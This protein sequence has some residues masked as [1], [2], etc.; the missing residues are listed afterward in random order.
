VDRPGLEAG[1]LRHPLGS[2]ARRRAQEKANTLRR[3]NAP[4]GHDQHLGHER[5]PDRGNLAFRKGETDIGNPQWPS[6]M[7]VGEDKDSA[8]RQRRKIE[9]FAKRAGFI[10]VDWFEDAAVSG[11]DDINARPGFAALLD[12]IEGNGVRTVL[13]EDASRFARKLMTQELGIIALAERGVTVLTANGDDLTN[14]DDEMKVAMRQIA[15]AFAQ[16]EKARLVRKLKEA[17]DRKREETGK[18]G[19]RKSYAQLDPELVAK[20]KELSQ[21]RPR[22]SL[23]EISAE[24]ERLGKVT[25]NGKA[26]SASAVQ[27]MVSRRVG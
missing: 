18:C 21:Q 3:E 2:A 14:T 10:V 5:E 11:S 12:R 9:T 13:I 26:Y 25:P 20:A 1:R 4:A 16:L 8:K 7:D 6:S 23:R 24:L 15:G 17:R 27:S 22:L 19:G